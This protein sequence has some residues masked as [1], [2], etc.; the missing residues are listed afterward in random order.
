MK[1]WHVFASHKWT[2]PAEGVVTLCRDLKNRGHDVRLFC[3]PNPRRLLADQA[4]RRGVTPESD[5][6]L[7]PKHP[8]LTAL[9]IRRL[10][11]MLRRERPDILHLHLSSDHWIGGLAARWAKGTTRIEQ[12]ADASV[13]KGEAP[14]GGDR[15]EICP[16]PGGGMVAPPII[17]RTIHHPQTIQSRPFRSRLYESLTDGFITLCKRDR[18][19]LRQ[20]YCI[21][22]KPVSVI[23]G[24]VDTT[25]FHSDAEARLGRAEFGLKMTTPVI[26][27]VARFQPHR[28]HDLMIAAMDRLQKS[29]PLIRLILVGRGEHRP[30]IEQLV[31]G[32][33]LDQRVIFAGY[34]DRDLPQ[35]YAAMDI[36]VM[37]AAG[38]DG[39]CRAAL[40]A[41][42]VGRPV[43]GFP[44]GALPE[45]IVEGVTGHLVPEGD[46]EALADC[47]SALL[48]D[49]PRMQAMGE[50]ARKRIEAEFT[51]AL[52]V[53]K[54]EEFYNSLIAKR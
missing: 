53:R 6:W 9:D 8:V 32:R 40:E 1:I 20:T 37:P 33:G 19:A 49:R 21:G 31:R 51:E 23:H 41:M 39:S 46:A 24:A 28:R 54:T 34:R 38:S 48:S 30:V 11:Q 22:P 12:R 18:E 50:A 26:G 27:M 45:T 47:L 36:L 10:K 25:R 7:A 43:V 17:V 42:A 3:T 5:L 15:F 29:V 44:V 35:I 52:R 16:H 13:G 2:G 4:V 14:K